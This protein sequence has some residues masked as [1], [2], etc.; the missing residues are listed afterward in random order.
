MTWILA[1]LALAIVVAIVMGLHRS[2]AR[3]HQHDSLVPTRGRRS[4]IDYPMS[5]GGFAGGDSGG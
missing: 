4:S 5:G 2:Y 1:A 3:R